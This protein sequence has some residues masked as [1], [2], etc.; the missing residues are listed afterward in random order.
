MDK[1]YISFQCN[2]TNDNLI[3]VFHILKDWEDTQPFE[4]IFDGARLVQA[5]YEINTTINGNSYNKEEIDHALR[6]KDLKGVFHDID[7]YVFIKGDVPLKFLTINSQER[8][9]QWISENNMSKLML[10]LNIKY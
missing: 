10:D 1:D 4:I 9:K 6:T 2:P 3:K 8:I 7:D 5:G